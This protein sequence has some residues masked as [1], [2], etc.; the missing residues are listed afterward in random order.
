METLL[1]L[2]A[3]AGLSTTADLPRKEKERTE[4]EKKLLK[5]AKRKEV[6]WDRIMMSTL[7]C[8]IGVWPLGSLVVM[9]VGFPRIPET[10]ATAIVLAIFSIGTVAILLV[11]WKAIKVAEYRINLE[12]KD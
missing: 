6:K 10:V 12:Y 1:L 3:A 11:G 4:E 7:V 8:G 5:E 9:T 2:L